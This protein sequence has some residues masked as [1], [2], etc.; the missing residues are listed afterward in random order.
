M[1]QPTPPLVELRIL[2]QCQFFVETFHH[3][4]SQVSSRHE[5]DTSKQQ[6]VGKP[7]RTQADVKRLIDK[8]GLSAVVHCEQEVLLWLFLLGR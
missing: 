2:V 1:M 8:D 5:L 6:Q 3:L 4:L 7:L